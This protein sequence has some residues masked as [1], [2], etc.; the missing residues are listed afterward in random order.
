VWILCRKYG[1]HIRN[2]TVRVRK[3]SEDSL[4]ST[5]T[6]QITSFNNVQDSS[7]VVRN[8]QNTYAT[9]VNDVVSIEFPSSATD[10]FT[11]LTNTSQGN[12]TGYT[13]RQHNGLHGL[14]K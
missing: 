13:G 9:A 2:I 10:G 11:L 1:N 3:A 14:T 12:P 6:W 4:V 8:R 5:G 7:F